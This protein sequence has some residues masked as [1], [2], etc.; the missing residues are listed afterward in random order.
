VN[1]LQKDILVQ[2]AISAALQSVEHGKHRELA[3]TRA[4]AQKADDER[5]AAL[6]E[7]KRLRE[8]VADLRAE[9]VTIA[10]ELTRLTD[11][12]TEMLTEH[13]KIVETLTAER[14]H[15]RREA[16]LYRS[17]RENGGMSPME[18]ARLRG[19]D[20]FKEER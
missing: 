3:A 16:C 20:C 5:Q 11:E 9:L 13:G 4:W 7:A 6:D 12:R 17:R 14:D 8:E 2:E 15:A 1:D 18:I 10:D 19:W